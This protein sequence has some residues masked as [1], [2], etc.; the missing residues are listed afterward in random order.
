M[1]KLE[2]ETRPFFTVVGLQIPRRPTEVR[3]FDIEFIPLK[4]SKGIQ[5]DTVDKLF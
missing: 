1:R 3:G 5:D 4:A 2:K